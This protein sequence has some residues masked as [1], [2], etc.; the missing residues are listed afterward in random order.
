M[1][2]TGESKYGIVAGRLVLTGGLVPVREPASFS[3]IRIREEGPGNEPN[4]KRGQDRVRVRVRA[5]VSVL[6]HSDSRILSVGDRSVGPAVV[7][8]KDGSNQEVRREER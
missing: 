2:T 6:D 8:L 7:I 5:G 4:T 1:F 3:F